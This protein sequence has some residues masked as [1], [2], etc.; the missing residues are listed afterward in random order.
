[1]DQEKLDKLPKWA[2]AY[3]MK[4]ERERDT[5]TEALARYQDS[6]T[7]S[8]IYTDELVCDGRQQAP[9]FI[10]RYIS[11]FVPVNFEY[12]NIHLT[13]R[14]VENCIELRW[15]KNGDTLSKV[16]VVPTGF[17]SVEL[18]TLIGRDSYI[19]KGGEQP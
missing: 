8:P 15:S 13:V 10:R 14:L 5:A 6:Q 2:Q 9:S 18:T 12:A 17:Q 7:E 4:I 16:A 11:S 3:I 19:R 1:M